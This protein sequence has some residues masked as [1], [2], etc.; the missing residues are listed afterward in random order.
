[1]GHYGIVRSLPT[2]PDHVLVIFGA[3]GDLARRKLLPALYHLYLE[4]MMPNDFRIIG[5]ARSKLTTA[6]FIEFARGALKD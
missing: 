6:E 5:N 1:M 2:P 4:G 3:N